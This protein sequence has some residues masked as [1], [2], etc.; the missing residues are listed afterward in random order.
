M[1]SH[2]LV[3]KTWGCFYNWEH[4]IW[5]VFWAGGGRRAHL[6]AGTSVNP[7][8]DSLTKQDI[9]TLIFTEILAKG[10]QI[11]SPLK[12]SEHPL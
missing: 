10:L 2:L 3:S 7:F 8:L 11:F 5:A 12:K 6:S 9:L 4:Y 1:Y